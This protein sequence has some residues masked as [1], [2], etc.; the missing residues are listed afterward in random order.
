MKQGNQFFLEIELLTEDDKVILPKEVESITFTFGGV[1]KIYPSSEVIFEN[2]LYKV[3]FSQE[4]T[5]KLKGIIS[6]DIRVKFNNNT[7][8]GSKIY[9]ERIEDSLNKEVL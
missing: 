9:N 7:I 3:W 5:F 6:Y 4:D 8:I 2:D 1:K